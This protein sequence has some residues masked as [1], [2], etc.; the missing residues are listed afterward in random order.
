MKTF[1]LS[2]ERTPERY[3]AFL[4]SNRFHQT[5]ELSPAVDGRGLILEDLQ[6]SGL[7]D[8]YLPF[9][10]GAIG[11]ALSHRK[12]WEVAVSQ[13]VPVTVCEDDANL[14]RHFSEVSEKILAQLDRNWDVVLWGW[15]FDS[16]FLANPYPNLST[17]LM[18][19]NQNEMRANKSV[20]LNA[21]VAPTLL[22]LCAVFGSVCYSISPKGA[23][24]FLDYCFPLRQFTLSVPEINFNMH[25]G[26]LDAVMCSFYRQALCFVCFP[27]LA[28]TDNDHAISTVQTQ[29]P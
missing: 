11:N 4:E 19:F 20:Y 16:I 25:V 23:R 6:S 12:L 14:H 2:L 18:Q 28:V 5:I 3:K 26:A 22:R 17:I 27:P 15:N 1:V 24:K 8:G 29:A 10:S 9:S 13:N 21:P 7:I